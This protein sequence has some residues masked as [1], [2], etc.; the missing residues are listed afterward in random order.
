MPDAN[1]RLLRRFRYRP[2]EHILVKSMQMKDSLQER[3]V[4]GS[5]YVPGVCWNCL[6][7]VLSFSQMFS[8]NGRFMPVDMTFFIGSMG[9][10]Y[11]PNFFSCKNQPSIYRY[12]KYAIPILWVCLSQT[13]FAF[14]NTVSGGRLQNTTCSLRPEAIK[15]KHVLVFCGKFVLGQKT[16]HE[17]KPYFGIFKDYI[18]LKF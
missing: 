14:G 9:L 11:L 12:S 6:R 4:K 10:V 2:V 3:V 7:R 17:V 5:G 15:I 18:S 8:I 16:C 1:P 13:S